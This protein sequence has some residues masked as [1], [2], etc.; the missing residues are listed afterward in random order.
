[1]TPQ[2]DNSRNT[3]ILLG[4][5][6]AMMLGYQYFYAQPAAEKARQQEAQQAAKAPDTPPPPTFL[7]RD[8]ALA[9]GPRVKID[10]PATLARGGL[11]GSINLTGG[12][13]DD[14]SLK[15]YLQE[16][17]PK[18]S[19]PVELFNPTQSENALFAETGWQSTGPTA[20]D[21][22]GRNTLWHVVSGTTL[23]PGHPVVIGFDSVG[24]LNFLRTFEV[25]DR[26][27]F[28]VTDTV[29]NKGAAPAPLWPYAHVVRRGLPP[30]SKSAGFEGAIGAFP[31]KGAAPTKM[32]NFHDLAKKRVDKPGTD[33]TKGPQHWEQ[34]VPATGGWYGLT[35]KYWLGAVIPADQALKVEADFQRNYAPNTPD[36]YGAAFQE[37]E[38]VV[39]P[40]T[41]VENKTYVFAGAKSNAVLEDYSSKLH[42]PNFKLAIDWGWLF[43]LTQ[44]L[45]SLLTFFHGFVGNWGWAILMLTVVVRGAMFP[46]AL[47][48]YASMSKMKKVQPQLEELKKKFANDATKIQQETMALYQREKI[49]PVAGCLPML[50]TIPIF[51]AL[52]NMLTVTIELRHQPFIGWIHDLSARDPTTI[53]ELFGLIKWHPENVPFIGQSILDSY[54]HIGVW[55]LLYGATTFLQMQMQPTPSTDPTQKMIMQF[56]P[57]VFMVFIGQLA[58]GLV[59]YYVWSNTI[60]VLQ[61]WFMMRRSGVDTPIDTVIA[62]AR[63]RLASSKAV[64]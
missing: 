23:S 14:V 11:F 40:G 9:S 39:A 45:F 2:P 7:P 59:I 3:F 36:L 25:D 12:L 63:A 10:T 54:L 55:P 46:L 44:P 35:D 43:F 34:V 4:V 27:M 38:R 48:S 8:K 58:V 13:I 28:T 52:N 50:L 6:L 22:P 32:I 37:P 1:M 60:T 30:P 42:I 18:K 15:G 61:Q 26:F 19:P 64:G 31:D 17:P 16:A 47:Q 5:M 29:I 56:F 24:G 33:D 57:L 49:N 62:R 53:L 21:V 20:A 51:I 41:S